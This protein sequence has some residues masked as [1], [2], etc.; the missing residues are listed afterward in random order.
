M[1]LLQKASIITTP[2]AYA[3]DYL[4]SIKPAYALGENLVSNGGFDTDSDWSKTTGWTISGGKA[5]WNPAVAPYN[6]DIY[7]AFS[8]VEGTR[9]RITFT[10]SNNTTGRILLR[11]SGTGNQDVNG[12]YTYYAN[13]T[14]TVEFKAQANKSFLR[15][16]GHDSYSSFSIDDFSLRIITDADFDFDRNST[17]TRV[18]E[19]YLIEDVPYNLLSYSNGFD[20]WSNSGTITRTGGQAGLYNTS[21]AWLITKGSA[22]AF[23]RQSNAQAGTRTFSV[24]AK[25]DTAT[26]LLLDIDGSPDAFQ[27]YDLSNGVL[28]ATGTNANAEIKHCGNGWYRCL[29]TGNDTYTEVRIYPAEGNNSVGATNT[30]LFLQNAQM[31]KGDQPKDYLKT[32]DR[33]D[34][35]RIDYT[36]GEPSILLEPQRVNLQTFSTDLNNALTAGSP[37]T[38]TSNVTTSPENLQNADKITQTLDTRYQSRFSIITITAGSTWTRSIFAKKDTGNWMYLQQYDGVT[39]NGAYFDLENGIIGSNDIGITPRMESYPN[40][41]YRCSVTHTPNASATTERIQVA[42]VDANNT[43]ANKT[44][45]GTGIFI[46]GAQLEEGSYPTSLIHTSGSAVTRSADAANNAGNSDL[47]NSTEGVLY[48]EISALDVSGGNREITLSDGTTSNRVIVQYRDNSNIRIILAKSTGDEFDTGVL[49]FDTVALNKIAIKYKT[50]DFAF[51][52]NGIEIYSD[53]TGNTFNA[54]TLS[55]INF[56]GGTGGNDFYGN[57][58][59]IAVFKEAL[60]DLE[61]EKLTGYNN[62]ELYMNYYNRLSYLGLAEEYNVE[63]DI[64]N[65]IL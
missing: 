38:I 50:N 12:G 34:I 11:L 13:G 45:N 28:G 43:S 10:M 22:G 52:V 33:L 20:N 39:N 7:R 31:V 37:V 6:N 15:I 53:N 59:M 29:V 18:N 35:P 32:T 61:L 54:N 57:A 64:N 44:G 8:F 62:H 56:D 21:D 40:G 5:N 65:Y 4:Y 41:W 3:E 60:T 47:I 63:S 36:N 1:S 51:W 42:L 58:K 9:Y 19:D 14:H 26:F 25:A 2:T 16:Y 30:Q 49:S 55:T 48:A 27:Y 23:I 24:Y 46:Y 17:G